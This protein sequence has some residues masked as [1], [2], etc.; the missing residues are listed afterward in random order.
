M[1]PPRS[2]S[3]NNVFSRQ[4]LLSHGWS[5]SADHDA[6]VYVSSLS[7]EITSAM[8]RANAQSQSCRGKLSRLFNL[9]GKRS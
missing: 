9:N 6:N 1:S 5:Q 8:E 3:V 4:D 7:G 2:N